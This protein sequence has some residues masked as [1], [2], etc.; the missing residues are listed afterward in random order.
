MKKTLFFIFAILL[1]C[2]F[3][4]CTSL[5]YPQPA[6]DNTSVYVIDTSK[7]RGSFEDY[8]KLHN[9]SSDSNISFRIYIHNSGSNEWITYGIGKLKGAGDT[10]TIDSGIKNIDRYRYFAIESMDGKKFK[11]EFYKNRNDLHI[12]IMND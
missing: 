9:V 6:F 7:A 5:N 3:N 8:V 2:I 10:D 12:N 11:Y 1:I 4:S